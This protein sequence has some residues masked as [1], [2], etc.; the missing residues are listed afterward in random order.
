MPIRTILPPKFHLIPDSATR[1]FKGIIHDIYQWEQELFDGTFTIFEMLKS[2]DAVHAMAI[3]DHKLVILKE[4]QPNLDEY[5]GLPGGHHDVP[6]ET[7][8]EAAQREMLEETGMTF[9]TWRLISVYQPHRKTE[10]FIY[11]FLATDFESQAQQKLDA[12]EKIEIM[13]LD[14]DSALEIANTK[15]AHYLPVELLKRV[16]SIDELA[17]LPL[18]GA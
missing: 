16:A 17:D 14:R 6:G 18:F 10:Q 3:K 8:I 15:S 4:Q 12:G 9:A 11:L 13:L 2:P 5:F 7:E 1:V